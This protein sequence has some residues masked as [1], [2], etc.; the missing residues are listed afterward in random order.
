MRSFSAW[1]ASDANRFG[2]S[3]D[4]I[5]VTVRRDPVVAHERLPSQDGQGPGAPSAETVGY[6]VSR[7]DGNIYYYDVNA[8]SNLVASAPEVVGFDPTARF[9]DYIVRAAQGGTRQFAA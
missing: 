5:E 4:Q 6:L 1:G 7:T 3:P 2:G 9:V 8:T